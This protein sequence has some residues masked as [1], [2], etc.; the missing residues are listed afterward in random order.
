APDG[1]GSFEIAGFQGNFGGETLNMDLKITELDNPLIN[2]RCH[3]ALPLAACYGLLGSADISSG[4]GSLRINQLELQ[5]RY[6]DM[7]DM[8]RIAAVRASGELQFENAGI[9]YK[10]V[11]LRISAGRLRL[12]D[13]LFVVDSLAMQAGRS[14][15]ALL[16]SARNLLPVLFSDSLNTNNALLEFSGE[17][18]CRQFDLSQLIEL[19]SVQESEAGGDQAALDSLRSA[20]NLDRQRLTDRLKGAFEMRIDALDYEKIQVRN[21]QGNLAFDHNQ[22]FVKG[23]AQTMQ[24]SIQLDGTAYFA[25]SPTLKMRITASDID[26]QTCLEQCQNFGQEVVTSENLRGRLSG[27][28]VLWAFWNE[29]N[30]FLMDKLRAYADVQARNGQLLGLKMLE[31]FSTYVHLEDLRDV[32]FTD[33]QNYLEI[34]NRRLYLPVMFIQNNALNMALSGVHTFDNDIDYKI[35]VNIGQTLLQRLK[36]RDAN[37]DPLPERRG[38]FNAYYSIVGNLDKYDMKSG[39]K[40]VKAEFERSEARKQRIAQAIQQ[41]FT[42]AY[43]PPPETGDDTEYLDPITGGSGRPGAVRR[44]QE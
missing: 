8:G 26:L 21:F 31:D 18:L 25:I 30:E 1:S 43:S 44:E 11:P 29:Q 17:L 20:G 10:D 19:F 13:N 3:G 33:L 24:G 35:K 38:W 7:L 39:K 41:E 36:G 23:Q 42:G 9:A 22:L 34:S 4:E 37:F 28:V 40:T 6:A 16:G 2:F 12:A 14:D 27:R 5:G 32:R 15:F